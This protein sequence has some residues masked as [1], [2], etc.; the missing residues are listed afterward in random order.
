MPTRK[1]SIVD[2]S[3]ALGD[4]DNKKSQAQKSHQ[5]KFKIADRVD[6]YDKQDVQ[7]DTDYQAGDVPKLSLMTTKIFKQRLSSWK[8]SLRDGRNLSLE[9]GESSAEWRRDTRVHSLTL[10]RLVSIS[11]CWHP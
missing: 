8:I 6:L 9:G 1:P 3:G 11:F 2:L 5:G 4:H 10:L 7:T